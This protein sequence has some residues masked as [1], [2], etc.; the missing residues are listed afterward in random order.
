[1]RTSVADIVRETAAKHGLSVATLLSQNRQRAYAWPRQEA[2][3]RIFTECPHISY[4]EAGRRLGG[5]DHTTILH[6]VKAHCQRNGIDYA[7]AVK[8]RMGDQYAPYFHKMM[9]AY[10]FAM[11][12]GGSYASAA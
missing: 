9:T 10:A 4:P 1:M 5:R 11:K 2:M 8:T 7:E 6:G 12:N 3:Y